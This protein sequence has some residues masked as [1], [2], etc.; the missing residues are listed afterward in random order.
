MN[1]S[2]P[3]SQSMRHVFLAILLMCSLY[4]DAQ[5]AIK[6]TA[7][8]FLLQIESYSPDAD[9]VSASK[10]AD[11]MMFLSE[12]QKRIKKNTKA[13]VA[14]YWNLLTVFDMVHESTDNIDIV[15][16][17]FFRA[18][19][20]CDYLTSFQKYYERYS[21]YI[22]T[23]LKSQLTICSTKS[24]KTDRK[25]FDLDEYV[26]RNK[27]DKTLV[28]NI[29]QIDQDDQVD[30]Y[31]ASVQA[32]LDAVNQEKI[33]KLFARYNCY[34]GKSLVGEKFDHVMW[35]VIQHSNLEMME[36]YLPVIHEAVKEKEL[37]ETSLK[38]LI[39]RVYTAKFNYQIFGSQVGVKAAADAI[40]DAVRKKYDID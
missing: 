39:D 2:I 30:R 18:D 19:G 13:D 29:Y 11:A 17:K 1:P 12:T 36:R 7:D 20:S 23:R 10:H 8:D 31:N 24:L 32:P 3:C 38:M 21:Q 26:R 9:G 15:L 6:F 14:D 22:Q 28:E 40:R 5:H 25:P 33:E 35:M 27:L 34:I 37:H 16:D 4:V